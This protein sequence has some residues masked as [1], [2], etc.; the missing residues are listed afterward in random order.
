MTQPVKTFMEEQE[1]ARIDTICKGLLPDLFQREFE[2]ALDNALD[3]NTPF[4]KKREVTLKVVITTN[5]ERDAFHIEAVTS[6]K[7]APFL[8]ESGIVFA[9]KRGASVVAVNYRADQLR[10]PIG[11]PSL[12]PVTKDESAPATSPAATKAAR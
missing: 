6:S 2:K 3:P 12:S 9:A 7:L 11:R 8:G 10:L 1:P 5:E 4:K